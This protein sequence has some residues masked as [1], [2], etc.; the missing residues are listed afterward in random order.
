MEIQDNIT[1]A[2]YTTFHIGG[3]AR[4]F[5]TCRTVEDLADAAAWAR[6][7]NVPVFIL[8]GGS[9][10]VINDS[11]FP[12][13]VIRFVNKGV[14][15][16]EETGESVTL[17]IGAGEVWDEVVKFAVERGYWGIENLSHIP[18]LAGGFAVQNVGAYGQEASNAIISVEIF[19][20]HD[21]TVKT[22]RQEQCHFDY[23]QSIF[24]TSA[25]GRFVIVSTRITLNKIPQP[26]LQYGDVKRYF[27]DRDIAA[28][29]QAQIREA[30]IAIRNTKFPFPK[31][32]KDGNAGSFFRG[33]ILQPDQVEF[34]YQ[35]VADNFGKQPLERLTAMADRLMVPQGMKTPTAF[36]VELCGLKGYQTGGAKVHDQHAAIV[37][38]ATGQA[39][40]KDVI[41]LF[42][43]VGRVVHERTGVILH[44]EPELVGFSEAEKEQILDSVVE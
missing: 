30:I 43:H 31:E 26:N 38:N 9:N 41:S 23:R 20:L 42:T 4:Y 5:C 11:G 10:V 40:A 29:T 37:V 6:A 8:G 18:G 12:G 34:L 35:K 24:N 16:V 15:I 36:L 21:Q 25:K 2:P 1:L 7:K 19:D 13:L 44:I 28:P 3:P 32:P 27:A 17:D 39:T 33:P 14:E 22:F